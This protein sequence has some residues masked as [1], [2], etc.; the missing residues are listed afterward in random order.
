MPYAVL[1]AGFEG[2]EAC[3]VGAVGFAAAA[4]VT[5]ATPRGIAAVAPGVVFGLAGAMLIGVDTG[6]ATTAADDALSERG[7]AAFVATG[8]VA[9][10][11][12]FSTARVLDA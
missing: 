1:G 11:G 4:A 8:D 9:G 12:G 7:D 3:V 10:S 5:G 6:G 2:S